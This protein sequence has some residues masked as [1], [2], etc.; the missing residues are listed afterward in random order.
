MSV[1]WAKVASICNLWREWIDIRD[2]WAT[3]LKIVDYQVNKHQPP[4]FKYPCLLF[5]LWRSLQEE[6][7]LAQWARPGAWYQL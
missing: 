4:M 6:M 3:I 2:E 1:P 5:T 7:K